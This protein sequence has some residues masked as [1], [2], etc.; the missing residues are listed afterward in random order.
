[1]S[2]YWG[3]Y[4]QVLVTNY[5]DFVLVGQDA[6]GKPIKLESYR[7]AE[8]ESAF[9][10]AAAHP[11]AAA[12]RH[13][14]RFIEYLTRVLLHSAVLTD[15]ADVA[16]FL[17]SYAREARARIEGAD[18]P[19]LTAVRKALQEALGLT[20]EDR[21]G[22]HFF[23]STL[24]QTL[25]YGLSLPGSS[26]ANSISRQI[27]KLGSIGILPRATFASRSSESYFMK[28]PIPDS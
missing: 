15:P 25:F 4:R 24:V 7:L 5:R 9:W 20:F 23:R 22:D 2:K 8:T 17:A 6:E 27:E 16:W 28:W 12:E 10:A 3:K 1:M 26:G 11:K 13:G 21:K 18:L 14:E 19:P